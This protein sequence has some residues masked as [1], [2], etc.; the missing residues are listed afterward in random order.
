MATTNNKTA[1]NVFFTDISLAGFLPL[2][3]FYLLC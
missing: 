1:T 2:L 3:I